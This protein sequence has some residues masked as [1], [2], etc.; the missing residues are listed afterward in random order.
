MEFKAG[1]KKGIEKVWI[2]AERRRIRPG[3]TIR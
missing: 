3:V 2:L 1:K